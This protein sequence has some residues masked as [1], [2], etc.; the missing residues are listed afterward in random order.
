[1]TLDLD[2]SNERISFTAFLAIAVH[3]IIILGIGAMALA[4]LEVPPTLNVTLAT[5]QSDNAPE[6]ADFL[7]QHNQEASGD[8]D[9][10]RELT[11]RE[12]ADIMASKINPVTPEARIKARQ[13]T[14]PDNSLITTTRPS[15]VRTSTDIDELNELQD[16]DGD[17]ADNPIINPEIASLRARLDRLQQEFARRPRIRQMTSVSTKS[18]ADAEYL[19]R[20]TQKVELLGNENFPRAALDNN[21]F[22][23]LRLSVLVNSD[24]SVERVEILKS[25]GYPVLDQA[26]VQIVRLASPFD[27]FPQEILKSAD[28]L[29]IIR[30]WRFEITGLKAGSS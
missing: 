5:Y 20:W 10:V 2:K 23:S 30:T 7:A 13:Q 17:D 18:S 28:Q 12:Q 15:R 25:S 3:A 19:H 29:D 14:T 11:T 1:M 16:L 8:A 4:P 24:G 21:I 22:G 9:D 6:Q 27:V 26:A